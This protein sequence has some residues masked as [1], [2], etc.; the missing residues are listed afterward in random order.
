[1]IIIR[2]SGGL[3]NQMFQYALFLQLQKL[4]RNVLFDDV[5]QYDEEAFRDSEQKRRPKRLDI[6]G[7][8][9]P[10]ASREDV[11]RLT[12]GSLALP[13]RIRRKLTGRKTLERDDRDFIFDLAF[14]EL[15]EGYFCGGFQ[16]PRY[17]EGCEQEVRSAFSFPEQLLEPK[18][19][20]DAKEKRI[21]E[22]AAGYAA[23]IRQAGAGAD[24]RGLR[25]RGGSASI[26]LRFGD[27]VAKGDVYGGI[28][29]DAYYNTAIQSLQE[30]DPEITFFVFS[31]DEEKAGEWIRYQA[32]RSDNLGRGRFVLVKGSDEDHGYLDLYL[33][34]LCRCHIIANS[35]FSWWGA[36]LCRAPGKIVFAPSIWN[37][38]KDGS[39]LARKDIYS[40]DM[41]RISPAGRF[42]S[43]TPLISVIVTAYNVAPYIAGALDS[44]RRQTWQNLDIIAVD[45]GST[46]GTGRILDEAAREDPRIRVVHTTNGGV[47]AARNAGLA[48]ARGEYIGFVDG[49]DYAHPE[50]YETLVRGMLATGAQLAAVNYRETVAQDGKEAAPAAEASGKAASA[51]IASLVENSIL[52]KQQDALRY[53]IRSGAEG[54][55]GRVVLHPSVWSK[56]FHQSVLKGNRFPEGTSAEDIPFTT[57]ALCRARKVLYQPEPLYDYVKNRSAS[58]MNTGRAIRTLTQE[59]P[60]WRSHLALLDEAG[61]ARLAEE[62]EYWFYR[63]MLFYEE[64]YRAC[65]DTKE[66]AEE[67]EKRIL[68][69][70]D[71]ILELCAQKRYGR[72]GDTKRLKLYVQSPKMYYRLSLLY[73]KTVVAW[74]RRG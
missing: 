8:E 31:N 30:V 23:R 44:V 34:T 12:D 52:L 14:L 1:M 65:E 20:A 66:Q 25:G 70:K 22:Q 73:E 62:S 67:L 48:C 6:F 49:D 26:H 43:E 32:E 17:F 47:S 64:D 55:D 46:D 2:M 40:G 13:N 54:T 15:E 60:A 37:N 61:F 21:L 69:H 9:Y 19:G 4:G 11:M 24:A 39:E 36:W 5:S 38:E 45:D 74:K 68:S 41:I 63:R 58:I 53:F 56:L 72:R 16:S 27:Y 35:S 50:L 51:R 29:T 33:M 7:I 42:M 10:T 28:C 57:Y 18:E 71:R 59:I 3:G